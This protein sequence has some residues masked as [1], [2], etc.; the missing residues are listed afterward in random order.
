MKKIFFIVF[1][2]LT[3]CCLNIVAKTVINDNSIRELGYK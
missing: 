3:I 1:L 2:F